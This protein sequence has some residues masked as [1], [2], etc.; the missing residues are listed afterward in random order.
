MREKGEQRAA[1]LCG[2]VA[3]VEEN[4]GDCDELADHEAHVPRD[5]VQ[6]AGG[7]VSFAGAAG[8]QQRQAVN[9]HPFIMFFT[10]WVSS[11]CDMW[12]MA[13]ENTVT[14]CAHCT[15]NRLSMR[16]RRTYMT[17][18]SVTPKTH[19]LHQ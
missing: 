7:R 2:D 11:P 18:A 3:H 10:A 15:L 12:K 9:A 4:S 5:K 14:Q 19:W 6:V 1:C 16:R 8:K 17:A 13:T